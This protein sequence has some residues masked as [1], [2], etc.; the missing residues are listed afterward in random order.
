VEVAQLNRQRLFDQIASA[1]RGRIVSGELV[2][3]QR[4]PA[5]REI[6]VAHGVSRNVV[7]EAVRAL[8]K[9]GLLDVRQGSGTY[10]SDGS[11]RAW[12][13]SLGLALSVNRDTRKFEDL[14]E[15]RQL[16]EPGTAAKAAKRATS[17]DIADL[18]REVALMDASMS[19]QKAF[20]AAD[21]R[22]H[23]VVAKASQNALIPTLLDP[24]VDLLMGLRQ[25][26]F[27]LE[28]SAASAQVF[29]RR[30]LRAIEARDAAA[31]MAAMQGHLRQIVRD[32]GRL[33][34][35]EGNRKPAWRPRGS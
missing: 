7:R 15:I 3:G 22:F 21:H 30:I 5:E 14:M 26:L 2:T 20:I 27:E 12:G 6:A 31:A 32:L 19:D 28:R 35:K 8:A 17:R 33:S 9:E 34:Q 16:I 18:R 24:I 29:H 4:L 25:D 10:V 11:S 23:V 1:I 13:D